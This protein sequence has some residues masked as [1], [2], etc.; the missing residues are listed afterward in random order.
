MTVHCPL[1]VGK[2]V[3]GNS[4]LRN[5]TRETPFLSVSDIAFLHNVHWKCCHE[6]RTSVCS[7]CCLKTCTNY[8]IS[9]SHQF[10][11][12]VIS[13]V[14]RRDVI[15][16]RFCWFDKFDKICVLP[17]R[18]EIQRTSCIDFSAIVLLWR[19]KRHL[20]ILPP[21]NTAGNALGCICLRVCHSVMFVLFVL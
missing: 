4:L 19:L 17:L 21:V 13:T 15:L 7:P 14:Y 18:R 1:K 3:S 16:Q 12:H 6:H 2:N 11:C 8:K 20:N 9:N 5:Y 10:G